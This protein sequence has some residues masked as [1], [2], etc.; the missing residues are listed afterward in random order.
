MFIEYYWGVDKVK[1]TTDEKRDL[2]KTAFSEQQVKVL[3]LLLLDSTG[4]DT[5]KRDLSSKIKDV[6]LD[7]GVAP[8]LNG[9][10]YLVEAINIK[11][12]QP[13]ESAMGI[14]SQI[15]QNNNT[16][17]SRVERGIRHAIIRAWKNGNSELQSKLFSYSLNRK[18]EKPENTL[19]IAGITLYISE[20]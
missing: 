6:L 16:T 2:L 9:F 3:E 10:G 7:I 4:E 15:A 11:I 19:F 17:C 12:E 20:K 1:L 18:K 8:N 14:Y 13:E 5:N